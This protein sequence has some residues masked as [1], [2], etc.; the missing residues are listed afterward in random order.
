M[1][2]PFLISDVSTATERGDVRERGVV[3]GANAVDAARR[4]V[5]RMLRKDAIVER[6][7]TRE[8]VMN[9]LY[10][11]EWRAVALACLLWYYHSSVG[12]TRW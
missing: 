9:K 3:W 5:M 12:M 6:F 2:S 4:E 10:E 11:Y 7:G 8:I 1:V